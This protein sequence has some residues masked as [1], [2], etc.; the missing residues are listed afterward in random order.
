MAKSVADRKY[1]RVLLKL[2]GE[3]LQGE[4][5]FGIDPS[6]LNRM[7]LEIGQLVGIGVQVGLV[8]GGGNLFRGAALNEA[9]LDRVTG[10]HM[11][12]LAT[13][14]NALALRDALERANIATTAMS[15][16]PM[17]GV[18]DRYDRRSAIRCLEQGDVVIFSAGTGNPFFTTDSAA[19]LRAIEIDAELMLKATK[20]D[21]VYDADPVLHADAVKFNELSYDSVLEQKLGV[22]DLTAICLCRD[23]AMPVRVFQMEKPGAL[24]N[25]IVGADEGTLI[26]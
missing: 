10:D 7:A 21:G 26:K 24:V 5:G 9:G 19:A 25:I 15:A 4:G 11:G 17:S 6:V 22:M 8:V 23:H 16:I 2:S 14:M 12:M 18:V 1:K 20:V 13:T 3:A